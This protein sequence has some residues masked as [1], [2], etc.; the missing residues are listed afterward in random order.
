MIPYV[1]AS[2]ETVGTAQVV[3]LE[4]ARGDRGG[5]QH[6]HTQHRKPLLPMK[7]YHWV[8]VFSPPLFPADQMR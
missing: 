2:L 6:P 1:E 5:A 7:S 8:V 4:V 3:G